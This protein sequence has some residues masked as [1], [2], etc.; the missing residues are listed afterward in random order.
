MV[1]DFS[2]IDIDKPEDFYD[3]KMA[4]DSN[5]SPGKSSTTSAPSPDKK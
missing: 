4:K 5:A 3:G 2:G 1:R